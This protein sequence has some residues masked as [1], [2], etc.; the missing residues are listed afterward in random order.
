MVSPARAAPVAQRITHPRLRAPECAAAPAVSRTMEMGRGSPQAESRRMTAVAAYPWFCTA[1][2]RFMALASPPE[3]IQ[4]VGCG[5]E[6][7]GHMTSSELE[8][9]AELDPALAAEACSGGRWGA[10]GSG[11]DALGGNRCG[12]L[13]DERRGRARGGWGADEEG[14]GFDA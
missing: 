14:A 7:G 6:P 3:L 11:G 1:T 10:K 8:P 4:S 12:V 9:Q 5:W 13:K 2:S